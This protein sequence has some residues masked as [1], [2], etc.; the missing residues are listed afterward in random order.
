VFAAPIGWRRS[1][2]AALRALGASTI[3]P[4]GGLIGPTM[5][6]WSTSAD[7]PSLSQLTRSTTT[8][9]ILTNAPG[10]IILAARRKFSVVR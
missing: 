1:T 8:F 3:L 4:G 5:G 6:A 9:V 7:K 2:P 10:A